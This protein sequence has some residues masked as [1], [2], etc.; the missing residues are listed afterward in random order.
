MPNIE[1]NDL[2]M[3]IQA[4]DDKMAALE[5]TIAELPDDD[6]K[7]ADLDELLFAYE[8]T[9]EA[10][11]SAYREALAEASNLPPYE[12]LVRRDT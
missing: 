7:V 4:V 9:A 2:V 5:R 1:G 10:L 3:I 8:N 6:D 11:K 12:S